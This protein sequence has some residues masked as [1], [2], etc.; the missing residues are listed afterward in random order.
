MS[1]SYNLRTTHCNT[2]TRKSV[3]RPNLNIIESNSFRRWFS[4]IQTRNQKLKI[5]HSVGNLKQQPLARKIFSH[6]AQGLLCIYPD[7][8][9]VRVHAHVHVY[10]YKRLPG[11]SLSRGNHHVNEYTVTCLFQTKGQQALHFLLYV[12]TCTRRRS[13]E[14]FFTYGSY[15]DVHVFSH[16]HWLKPREEANF[17][18]Y[19]YT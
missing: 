12:H 10:R 11:S 17:T 8:S 2:P 5:S 14:V 16:F 13:F 19:T 9:I 15:S 1:S 6:T 7:N 4:R 3:K 18:M